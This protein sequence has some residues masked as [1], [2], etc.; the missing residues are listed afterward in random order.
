[1]KIWARLIKNDKIVKDMIYQSALKMSAQNY[2]LWLRDICHQLDIP[3]PVLIPQHYKNFVNFH[4]TR[5]KDDDFIE[6]LDY[7]MFVVEDCKE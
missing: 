6:S 1:M 5:F 3:N 2:E 4:N 7:D